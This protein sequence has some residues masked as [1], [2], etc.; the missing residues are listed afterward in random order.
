[1]N[2]NQYFTLQLHSVKRSYDGN[3]MTKGHGNFGWYLAD[4]F[5]LAM[6]FAAQE[7]AESN[8]KLKHLP[9]VVSGARHAVKAFAVTVHDQ[10]DCPVARGHSHSSLLD[11]L[12]ENIESQFNR[13]AEPVKN[14]LRQLGVL[15]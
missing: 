9:L 7:L 6:S 5:Y 10:F 12:V 15:A 4:C 11:E 14:V 13:D 2:R 3:G 8:P 1:M